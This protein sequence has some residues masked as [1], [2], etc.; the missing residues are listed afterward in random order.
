MNQILYNVISHN[1]IFT[2]LFTLC[3]LIPNRIGAQNVWKDSLVIKGV[4]AADTEQDCSGVIAKILR[5]KTVRPIVLEVD[6]RFKDEYLFSRP[7]RIT[8]GVKLFGVNGAKIIQESKNLLIVQGEAEVRSIWFGGF[9]INQGSNVKA[10]SVL[11]VRRGSIIRDIQI[12]DLEINNTRAEVEGNIPFNFNSN[13]GGDISISGVSVDGV[14]VFARFDKSRFTGITIRDNHVMRIA[15]R[16]VSLTCECENVTIVRN[17]FIENVSGIRPS[18][19]IYT[20]STLGH[21]SQGLTRPVKNLSVIDNEIRGLK[22]MAFSKDSKNG[23]SADLI[24]IRNVDGFIVKDNSLF[25]GGE[26]GITIAD[27]ARDG[28]VTGNTISQIDTVA[29]VIG[30][31][32]KAKGGKQPVERITID[33]NRINGFALFR[34]VASKEGSMSDWGVSIHARSA[35][36][37]VNSRDICIVNNSIKSGSQHSSYFGIWVLDRA[38]PDYFRNINIAAGNNSFTGF[39]TNEA[40]EIAMS[41]KMNGKPSSLS[42]SVVPEQIY[43]KSDQLVSENGATNFVC[44]L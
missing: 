5:E 26:A 20:N 23:A 27:G 12:E 38:R 11:R 37:V 4:C 35:I 18:N 15:R 31:A 24:T 19:F 44:S 22:N 30:A 13:V 40:L 42:G 14:Y 41:K 1:T 32:G 16:G 17:R 2:L 28:K 34:D 33:S 36:R 25:N 10:E 39:N 7:V 29:I 9:E 21:K 43:T 3:F 8:S 6:G